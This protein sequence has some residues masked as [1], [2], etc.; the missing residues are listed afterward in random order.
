MAKKKTDKLSKPK[1]D[2]GQTLYA[3][4]TRN[5]DYYNNLSEDD[6][7]SYVPLILMRFMSSAPNQGE[8][9]EYHLLSVNEIVNQDFWTL[10]KHPELQHQLLSLCGIGKK[11]FHSWIPGAKKL[12]SS[13]LQKFI[14]SVHP[15]L[16]SLEYGIFI[17]NNSVEEIEQLAKDYALDDKEIKDIVEQFEKVKV[18]AGN[19]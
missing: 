1:L 17:K 2:L 9:H 18:D 6:R 4:D 16:N 12:N 19:D 10:S 5:L 13:K 11:Q 14:F 7:K 3:L 8:L 15:D